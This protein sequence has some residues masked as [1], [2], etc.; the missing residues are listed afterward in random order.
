MARM[1][2][3]S[4]IIL[5]GLLLLSGCRSLTPETKPP[6]PVI[7]EG[8]TI[9]K[10]ALDFKLQTLAGENVSL[11]DFRGKPVLLNFWA[12]W[13]GPCKFEMPFLQAINDSYSDKGLVVLVVDYGEKPAVIEK[14]MTDLN[15]SM[16]VPMDSDGK[17]TKAFGIGALPTTFLIDKEGI[18]RQKVI[19]AFASEE[20]IET[21]LRKIM[22]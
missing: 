1:I 17:V 18:I 14:F 9:G 19:G 4:T 15:L 12:T 22:P 5:L 16:T 6:P 20:A 21:E 11:S 10:R 7:P 3:Q 8:I 2:S 13:C